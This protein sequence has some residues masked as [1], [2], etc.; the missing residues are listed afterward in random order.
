MEKYVPCVLSSQAYLR[1][2]RSIIHRQSDYYCRL[3]KILDAQSTGPYRLQLRTI[4]FF[5]PPPVDH[6]NKI[7]VELNMCPDV[8]CNTKLRPLLAIVQKDGVSLYCAELIDLKMGVYEEL[9]MRLLSEN[10]QGM[11][12]D[13]APQSVFICLL[14]DKCSST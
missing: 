11:G 3:P 2:D 5:P 12:A 8:Y 6:A 10:Q 4:E 7:F 9:H 13:W 1:F 14:L